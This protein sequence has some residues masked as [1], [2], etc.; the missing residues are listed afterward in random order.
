MYS[1]VYRLQKIKTTKNQ[2]ECVFKR[3]DL[4]TPPRKCLATAL[5][6]RHKQSLSAWENCLSTGS[7]CSFL[8]RFK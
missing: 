2:Q 3:L 6:S 1:S 4:E 7:I 8:N 5:V